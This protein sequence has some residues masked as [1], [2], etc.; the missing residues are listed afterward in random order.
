MKDPS[1]AVLGSIAFDNVFRAD[2]L[3]ALGGRTTAR[4]L[5]RYPGGMG[6]N[7]AMQISRIFGA[8]RLIGRVGDDASGQVLLDWFR[9]ASID[10]HFISLDP[11]QPT[12]QTYMFLLSDHNY[13][14]VVTPG[15]NWN[16]QPTEVE[17]AIAALASVDL[18]LLQL[19][20]NPPTPVTALHAARRCGVRTVLC[21]SP[22]Q[23]CTPEM[24]DLA[25]VLIANQEEAQRLWGFDPAMR[26]DLAWVAKNL[27]PSE[28]HILVITLGAHGSLA[29]Q[30]RQ[31][32][33]VPTLEV[34][35][36]DT[37]GAGDSFAGTFSACLARGFELERALAFG[38]IAGALTVTR[39]GAQ[40][41]LPT[42]A[43]IEGVYMEERERLRS[44]TRR[45]NLGT[46]H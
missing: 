8:A 25:D 42:L 12:G 32:F 40:S 2:S 1:V 17:E 39:V 20:I 28:R 31:V 29:I 16:T 7:Q 37:I 26:E 19:E 41:A 24:M 27:P 11:E 5:G 6:A 38:N 4:F 46:T 3:P 35:A 44:A 34:N 45:I 30:N 36:V 15:A 33:L 13:F 14:S 10:V 9:N 22:A 23:Y 18:L 43:E 21:A